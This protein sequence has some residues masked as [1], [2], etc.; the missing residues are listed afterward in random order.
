[1][2]HMS[3]DCPPRV[4]TTDGEALDEGFV[5]KDIEQAMRFAAARVK[6]IGRLNAD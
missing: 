6:S 3:C 2:A 4:D 5:A 1:M